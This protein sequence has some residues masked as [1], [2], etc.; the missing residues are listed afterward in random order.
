MEA[1]VV[2]A[3]L[4]AIALSACAHAKPDLDNQMSESVDKVMVTSGDWA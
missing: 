4:V 2:R 3:A 1:T